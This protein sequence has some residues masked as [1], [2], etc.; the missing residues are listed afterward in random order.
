MN[1]KTKILAEQ[2]V[3]ELDDL[4]REDI[5]ALAIMRHQR[6]STERTLKLRL[7]RVRRMVEALSKNNRKVNRGERQTRRCCA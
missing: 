5:I 1:E 6:R 4:G 7:G 3:A 2:I